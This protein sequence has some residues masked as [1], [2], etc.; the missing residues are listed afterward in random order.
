MLERPR[1]Q[2]L[3][4]MVAARRMEL[5]YTQRQV[6]DLLQMSEAYLADIESGRR[7]PRTD[8]L[9]RIAAVLRLDPGPLFEAAG[10]APHGFI[11]TMAEARA[12]IEAAKR[13]SDAIWERLL[14]HVLGLDPQ[15]DPEEPD[16]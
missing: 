1:Y 6:S 7:R 14:L 12:A 9:L 3:G 11:P 15:A 5:R 8:N 13:E 4:Q 16:T 2:T 10:Y